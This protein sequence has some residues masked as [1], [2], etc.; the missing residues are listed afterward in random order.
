MRSSRVSVKAAFGCPITDCYPETVRRR[1]P[2]ARRRLSTRRPPGVLI[3]TRKPCVF[4]RCRLFG[5][6][7]RFI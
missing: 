5:W 3:L 1:R 6:K 4:L 2:F 7:V